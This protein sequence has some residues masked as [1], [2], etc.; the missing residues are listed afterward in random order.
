MLYVNYSSIQWGEKEQTNRK[1]WTGYSQNKK[2]SV[3]ENIK[4]F[5]KDI[6]LIINQHHLTNTKNN[7]ILD[8][9]LSINNNKKDKQPVIHEGMV[10]RHSQTVAKRINCYNIY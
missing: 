6:Q 4:I 7:T 3:W 1:T 2:A 10:N 8:Q 9:I 5:L